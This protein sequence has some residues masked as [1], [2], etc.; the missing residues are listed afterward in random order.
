MSFSDNDEFHAFVY[1][2]H[3]L[4]MVNTLSVT[5]ALNGFSLSLSSGRNMDWLA[6]AV[7]RALACTVK[8]TGEGP[9]R[10]S[11]AD[12]R[13][14]LIELSEAVAA[15]WQKLFESSV[16]ADYRIWQ[17]SLRLWFSESGIGV[18]DGIDRGEPPDY[19]RFKDSVAELDRL[20]RFLRM[21]ALDTESQRGPWRQS[22]ERQLRLERGQYL[23]PIFEYAFGQRVSAN[24]WPSGSHRE[25]SAFMDFYQRMVALAFGEQATP[26]ISGV[27]KDA[28]RL[29]RQQPVQFVG[30]M[31]PGI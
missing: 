17:V 11:N 23:A 26:D 13:L 6:V 2:D 4:P 24:N 19:R 10:K 1:R 22:E 28:C 9:Q 18:Y 8:A 21:V 29:H 27:L 15:T 7:R 3:L 5:N 14:E 16:Y 30:G 12:I 25:R 31:I 20:A